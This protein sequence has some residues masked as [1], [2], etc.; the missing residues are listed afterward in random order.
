LAREFGLPEDSPHLYARYPMYVAS[1]V[2][3]GFG[4]GWRL[5][6]RRQSM[7]RSAQAVAQHVKLRD[8]LQRPAA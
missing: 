8:W 1:R 7:E 6:T 5:L 2:A 3:R 4:E